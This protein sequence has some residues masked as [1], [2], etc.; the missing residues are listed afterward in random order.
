MAT[1]AK[2]L[3][4]KMQF[5]LLTLLFFFLLVV[6]RF[7]IF[8]SFIIAI[9]IYK[10]N[11][12]GP[13]PRQNSDAKPCLLVMYCLKSTAGHILLSLIYEGR[14][15]SGFMKVKKYLVHQEMTF[16]NFTLLTMH[17]SAQV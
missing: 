9:S 14:S 2:I 15:R 5:L 16:I 12:N 3:H 11:K 6:F 13:L 10:S 1:K 4:C 17:S 8:F 7:F